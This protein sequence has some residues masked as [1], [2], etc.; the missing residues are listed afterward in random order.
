MKYTLILPIV[1]LAPLALVTQDAAAEPCAAQEANVAMARTALD[2][3]EDVLDLASNKQI[4]HVSA[5]HAM[6]AL[7][8]SAP[9]PQFSCLTCAQNAAG[10]RQAQAPSTLQRMHTMTRWRPG[11]PVSRH[12]SAATAT[13]SATT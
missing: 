10:V 12:T 11:T 13:R 2:S 1:A 8:G 3:A 4:L 7:H 9:P 6:R 5:D